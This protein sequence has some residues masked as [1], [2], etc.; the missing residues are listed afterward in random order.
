[1]LCALTCAFAAPARAGDWLFTPFI[2]TTFGADTNFVPPNS[3]VGVR[4]TTIGGSGGFLTSGIIGAEASATYSFGFFTSAPNAFGPASTTQHTALS[5]LM[6][7]ALFAVPVSV[8]HESLRPYAVLGAGMMHATSQD[9]I[10]FQPITR[11][12]A[13]MDVGGGAIG[14]VNRRAG[15]RFDLR[16]FR[17]LERDAATLTPN[18]GGSRLTFWRLSVGVVVR[19]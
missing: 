10:S 5:T 17:S 13:A 12:I 19:Y 4:K 8:T 15:V 18:S 9:L 3:G 14:F 1:M 2:G 11:T 6:G 16:R 7:D